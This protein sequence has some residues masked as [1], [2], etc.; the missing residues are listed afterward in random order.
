MT[1]MPNVKGGTIITLCFEKA[2]RS[3]SWKIWLVIPPRPRSS[4][5]YWPKELGSWKRKFSWGEIAEQSFNSRSSYFQEGETDV[6]HFHPSISPEWNFFFSIGLWFTSYCSWAIVH[7]VLFTRGNTVHPGKTL[8][9]LAHPLTWALHIPETTIFW[10]SYR[11]RL[12]ICACQ[13]AWC[14]AVIFG[15]CP[16]FLVYVIY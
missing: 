13:T 3:Y 1:W 8:L 5:F 15:L 6:G 9:H 7:R 2:G 4:Q 10:W 16:S 14:G 12:P 11:G